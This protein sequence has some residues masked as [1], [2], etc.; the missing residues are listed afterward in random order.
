MNPGNESKRN[1]FVFQAKWVD[2]VAEKRD[3]EEEPGDTAVV[4]PP[5]T[6]NVI[7]NGRG[8]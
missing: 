4:S 6:E 8:Y 1:A 2:N 5:V 3:S 7:E